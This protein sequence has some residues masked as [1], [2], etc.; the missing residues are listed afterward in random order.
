MHWI[1]KYNYCHQV[2]FINLHNFHEALFHYQLFFFFLCKQSGCMCSFLQ[3]NNNTIYNKNKGNWKASK[4]CIFTH[5]TTHHFC[6]FVSVH[7]WN[8]RSVRHKR[9]PALP[10]TFLLLV[11]FI[12]VLSFLIQCLCVCMWGLVWHSR[13]MEEMLRCLYYCML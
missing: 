13:Q 3:K 10:Q 2:R 5:A 12:H 11:W 6:L 7:L 4:A 9:F 8:P 1:A